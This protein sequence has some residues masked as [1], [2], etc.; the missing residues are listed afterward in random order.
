MDPDE[1]KKVS[2]EFYRYWAARALVHG[3]DWVLGW[4]PELKN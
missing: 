4:V 3:W 1:E 2:P